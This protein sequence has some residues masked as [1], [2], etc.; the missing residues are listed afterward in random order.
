MRE[1]AGHVEHESFVIDEDPPTVSGIPNKEKRRV[2]ALVK[3]RE[4]QAKRSPSEQYGANV[5]NNS[6]L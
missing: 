6:I 2:I 4:K 1:A 3:Q 5:L